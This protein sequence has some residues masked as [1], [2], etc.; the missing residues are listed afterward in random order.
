MEPNL[1]RVYAHLA[2]LY[3]RGTALGPDADIGVR[4]ALVETYFAIDPAI[5]RIAPGMEI[6]TVEV[7]GRAAEWIWPAGADTRTRLLY[8]HGGGWSAGSAASHRPFIARLAA[9]A[10]AAVLVP[11]YRLAPEHPFPAAL[12]DALAALAWMREHGPAGAAPARRLFLGG[13]SAG[14]N[15]AC[16]SLLALKT[17]GRCPT[18]RSRCRRRSTSA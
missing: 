2:A 18:P 17:A 6:R 13:D 4:R 1:A 7:A 11:E 15:L 5:T 16:A 10:G 3:E 14:G 12:D 8:L 9:A